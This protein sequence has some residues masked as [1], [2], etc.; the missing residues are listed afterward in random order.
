MSV[1]SKVQQIFEMCK[2]LTEKN[3]LCLHKGVCS[4]KRL[5]FAQKCERSFGGIAIGKAESED[6]TFDLIFF[7]FLFLNCFL[8][9]NLRTLFEHPVQRKSLVVLSDS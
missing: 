7:A 2:I 8:V 6:T 3:H 5:A 4:V 1:S 9:D